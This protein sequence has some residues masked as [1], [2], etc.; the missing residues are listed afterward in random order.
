MSMRITQAEK[1]PSNADRRS[2]RTRDPEVEEMLG[3]TERE[4]SATLD[5]EVNLV[6]MMNIWPWR[7]ALYRGHESVYEPRAQL[8][9]PSGPDVEQPWVNVSDPSS[10]RNQHLSVQDS[11][12]WTHERPQTSDQTQISDQLS[13]QRSRKA[14]PTQQQHF[15]KLLLTADRCSCFE[16][17]DPL[18]QR[19]QASINHQ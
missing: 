16:L 5:L 13:M 19:E 17:V 8:A 10:V 7:E 12:L 3:A 18:H 2:E 15:S 1:Y 9:D 14:F 11:E 6:F 4:K